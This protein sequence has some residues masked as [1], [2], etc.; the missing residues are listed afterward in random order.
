MILSTVTLLAASVVNACCDGIWIDHTL[1]GDS[2]TSGC[3]SDY[4]NWASEQ[5]DNYGGNEQYA[6]ISYNEDGAWADYQT[7]NLMECGCQKD[8]TSGCTEVEG[9]RMIEDDVDGYCY[10]VM[11][12]TTDWETCS[13]LCTSLSMDMLCI[14]DESDNELVMSFKECTTC[15]WVDHCSDDLAEECCPPV[16]LGLEQETEQ[17]AWNWVD[18]S[19]A[20][21]FTNWNGGQTPGFYSTD[22]Y[23]AVLGEWV[24]AGVWYTAPSSSEWTEALCGCQIVTEDACDTDNGWVSYVSESM[25]QTCYLF[26][27]TGMSFEDCQLHCAEYSDATM[28]CI[29]GSGDNDFVNDQIT[30]TPAPPPFVFIPPTCFWHHSH[31]REELLW[32]GIGIPCFIV[33][34]IVTVHMVLIIYSGAGSKNRGV[35]MDGDATGQSPSGRRIDLSVVPN[36]LNSAYGRLLDM[37]FEASETET[38]ISANSE[39]D[40]TVNMWL[41]RG[42]VAEIVFAMGLGGIGCT[43]LLHNHWI[44][45]SLFLDAI[46]GFV[47]FCSKVTIVLASYYVYTNL[48]PLSLKVAGI[49]IHIFAAAKFCMGLASFNIFVGYMIFGSKDDEFDN[50]CLAA[51]FFYSALLSMI[52]FQTITGVAL[53][54]VHINVVNSIGDINRFYEVAGV[55]WAILVLGTFGVGVSIWLVGADF[56]IQEDR[57]GFQK[58]GVYFSVASFFQACAGTAI[59]CINSRVRAHFRG[60]KGEKTIQMMEKK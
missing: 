32:Y 24:T 6:A 12:N 29:T 47:C 34:A 46:E 14:E 26:S 55:W 15:D 21:E 44:A 1:V 41:L 57:D 49:W 11:E 53:Y 9:W 7:Y 58:I 43:M 48:S 18:S 51:H 19:C 54:G 60:P 25:A 17:G 52:V 28:L 31:L 42:A 3:G 35:N 59:F 56:M 38:Q 5:P 30:C 10:Y 27:D 2:Y 13:T 20:S 37:P 36:P 23:F 8:I 39:V 22:E 33:M 4:E 16:W 45:C 50:F 40:E